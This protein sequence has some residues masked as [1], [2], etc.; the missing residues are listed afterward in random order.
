M[1]GIE[2]FRVFDVFPVGAGSPPSQILLSEGAF[3]NSFIVREVTIFETM[4]LKVWR[5]E[6][7]R[8]EGPKSTSEAGLSSDLI[9]LPSCFH[10]PFIFLPKIH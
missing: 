5:I 2:H 3:G 7:L 4:Q 6:N 9:L 10:F 8:I 1:R